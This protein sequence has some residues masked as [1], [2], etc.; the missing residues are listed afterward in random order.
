MDNISKQ[1]LGRGKVRRIIKMIIGFGLLLTGIFGS[2]IVAIFIFLVLNTKTLYKSLLGKIPL[3]ISEKAYSGPYRQIYKREGRRDLNLDIYYPSG[4]AKGENG[5]PVIFF[6]H[7]GGWISGSRRQSNNMSWCKF[8]AGKGFGV[9]AIDYRYGYLNHIEDILGDYEAALDFIR[10]KANEF[11][12]DKNSIVLMGLSAGGHLTLQYAAYNTHE[13]KDKK[14]LG[15]KG[16]VAWYAPCDLMDLWDE[17]V[18]SL[19]AR[20]AVTTT[21]KGTPEKARE[22]YEKYSPINWISSRMPPVFLVHGNNDSV[23]PVKSSIKLYKKL[24]SFSVPTWIRI[25]ASG[26]H[27]FEFQIKSRSTIKYIEETVNFV[28]SAC[29]K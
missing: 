14:M 17:N 9:V 13:R 25:E 2:W 18:E 5:F 28:R 19:F 1:I 21:L 10:D 20:V 24:V 29:K 26:E 16:V 6:A 15:I 3:S 22:D 27:S 12:L 11:F 7:G 23:V 8:L 4:Y